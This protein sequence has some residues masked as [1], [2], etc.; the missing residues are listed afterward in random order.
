MKFIV[1]ILILTLIFSCSSTKS[2]VAKPSKKTLKGTWQVNNIKFVGDKGLYK[3]FLFDL[4]DSACFKNSEWVFIPNN[5]SGK[6]TTSAT[7]SQC[8][9]MTNNIHWSFND[10]GDAGSLFQFK[11]IDADTKAKKVT[12]GYSGNIDSLNENTMVL[13]VATTYEGNAFD[14]LMTFN[15][16][17]DDIT[18]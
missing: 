5:G 4:A 2:G 11:Y 6:F 13:R 14:V 7:T 10:T 17:S 15:K 3:A 8:E 9:V 12:T 1:R 16:V 18:L